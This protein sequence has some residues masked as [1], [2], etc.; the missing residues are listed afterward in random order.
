MILKLPEELKEAAKCRDWNL[1]SRARLMAS[2]WGKLRASAQH[3][4]SP[5]VAGCSVPCKDGFGSEAEP[6]E[7]DRSPEKHCQLSVSLH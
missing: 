7:K 4:V 3:W 5:P 6:G 1:A 2:P